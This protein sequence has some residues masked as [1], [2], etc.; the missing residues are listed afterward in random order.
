MEQTTWRDKRRQGASIQR[1]HLGAW[2]YNA[3]EDTNAQVRQ[4]RRIPKDATRCS[5]NPVPVD[6]RCRELVRRCIQ[7]H[8]DDLAALRV[9]SQNYRPDTD[10]GIENKD[11]LPRAYQP[12]NALAFGLQ[13]RGE[14]AH[15]KV[16]AEPLSPLHMR[17]LQA[18]I[19]S[20]HTKAWR[21]G[22]PRAWGILHRDDTHPWWA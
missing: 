19:P 17:R 7:L 10:T 20:N 5:G 14:E 4:N 21:A 9:R 18:P 22:R 11:T 3:I 1:G 8:P 6:I 13:L 15:S 16:Q 2:H 12:A